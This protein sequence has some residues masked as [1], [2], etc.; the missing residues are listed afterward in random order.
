MEKY[1]ASQSKFARRAVSGL[2]AI[3]IGVFILTISIF[4]SGEPASA[5]VGCGGSPLSSTSCPGAGAPPTSPNPGYPIEPPPGACA[6]IVNTPPTQTSTGGNGGGNASGGPGLVCTDLT[7]PLGGC[8]EWRP[9]PSGSGGSTGGSNPGSSGANPPT[10]NCSDWTFGTACPT[11]PPPSS[12]S[13]GT[14]PGT[15]GT[16]GTGGPPSGPV[17]TPGTPGPGGGPASIPTPPPPPVD[18]NPAINTAIGGLAL[19]PTVASN[20]DFAAR[21]SLVNVPTWFWLASPDVVANTATV[22]GV[23]VTATATVQ[24]VNWDFGVTSQLCVGAGVPYQQ[25]EPA[26]A[27]TITFEESSAGVGSND[28]FASQAAVTWLIQYQIVSVPAAGITGVTIPN[29]SAQGS[30]ANFEL[31]VGEIQVLN[32]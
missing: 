12:G 14:T 19:A 8:N 9:V 23:T 13:G 1:G 15:G 10:F 5:Q 29:P 28:A 21:N 22:N 2:I 6:C 31:Q 20:P 24:N 26:T 17:G 18:P 7:G 27:C 3:G 32:N 25:P 30:V 11:S 16:G 4:A